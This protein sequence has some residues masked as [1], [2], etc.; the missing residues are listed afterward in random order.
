M[1]LPLRSRITSLQIMVKSNLYCPDHSTQFSLRAHQDSLCT[2]CTV[3]PHISRSSFHLYLF[4]L[5]WSTH[6]FLIICF[7]IMQS[8]KVIRMGIA[9]LHLVIGVSVFIIPLFLLLLREANFRHYDLKRKLMA[10]LIN[11]TYDGVLFSCTQM[12]LFLQHC[13]SD[14]IGLFTWL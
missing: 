3:H 7:V 5:F 11:C 14:E 9:A 6:I 2:I 1:G 13:A 10:K 4:S 12:M 8:D